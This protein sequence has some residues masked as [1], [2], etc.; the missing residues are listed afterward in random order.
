MQGQCLPSKLRV[1]TIAW[2]EMHLPAEVAYASRGSQAARS[3][4]GETGRRTNGAFPNK[5]H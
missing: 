3:V 5:I 2:G 1:T 4:A